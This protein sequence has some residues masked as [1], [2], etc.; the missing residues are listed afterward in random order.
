M[1]QCRC[2]DT[3]KLADPPPPFH[4][5]LAVLC[6]ERL[7]SGAARAESSTS[8]STWTRVERKWVQPTDVLENLSPPHRK[9]AVPE[10]AGGGGGGGDGDGAPWAVEVACPVCEV[11]MPVAGLGEH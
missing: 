10:K 11:V 3:D 6:L 9:R 2:W 8:F 1:R 5:L 7:P 4:H